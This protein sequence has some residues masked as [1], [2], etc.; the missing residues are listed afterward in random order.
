MSVSNLR[1]WKHFL[2]VQTNAVAALKA[3]TE[4]TSHGRT[5]SLLAERDIISLLEGN[6][7]GKTAVND[8]LRGRDVIYGPMAIFDRANIV[9]VSRATMVELLTGQSARAFLSA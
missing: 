9:A 2:Q 6:R 5:Y 3:M 4:V 8:T 1:N 7:T